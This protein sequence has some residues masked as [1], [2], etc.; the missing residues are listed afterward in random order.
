V[1]L[2]LI[3]IPQKITCVT[4]ENFSDLQKMLSASQFFCQYMVLDISRRN[5]IRKGEKP[6]INIVA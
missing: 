3:Q 2:L 4:R 6:S 1:E 5:I